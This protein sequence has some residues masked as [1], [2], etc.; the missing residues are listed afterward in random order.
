[1][2]AMHRLDLIIIQRFKMI[3]NEILR[4][5][6]E[7]GQENILNPKILMTRKNYIEKLTKS[8]RRT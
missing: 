6:F 3:H 2:V 5:D 8:R 4:L 7:L 1:M